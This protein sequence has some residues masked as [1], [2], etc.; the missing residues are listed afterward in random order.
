MGKYKLYKC[1]NS[2]CDELFKLHEITYSFVNDYGWIELQCNKCGSTQKIPVKNPSDYFPGTFSNATIINRYEYEDGEKR[3]FIE[4]PE[5]AIV[6]EEPCYVEWKPLRSNPFWKVGLSGELKFQ[7]NLR[8]LNNLIEKE[9][10]NFLN[11]Y[12][13][14]QYRADLPKKIIVLLHFSDYSITW[15][16]TVDGERDINTNNLYLVNHSRQQGWPDG[17]YDRNTLLV[18]LERC[19]M[20]WKLLAN[21]VVVVTPFI[22]FQYKKKE[23]QENVIALW[24]FLNSRLD[25]NKTLFVTR[26]ETF[27][28]L[29]KNQAEIDVPF[30]TLKEW[31]LI[32]D[33]Q[34]FVEDQKVKTKA[35]FHCKFYAGVFDDHVELFAGSYNIHTG[36]GL[37]QVSMRN[38]SKDSFKRMYMDN[39]VENFCYHPFIDEDVLFV[40]GN[41]ELMIKCNVIKMSEL[42]QIIK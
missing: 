31:H 40:E 19:L 3:E 9:L 42:V 23:Y 8:T 21:Q 11:Y 34:R 38:Y 17:V 32:D 2:D 30:E 22:G 7:N 26:R 4:Q 35:R 36:G 27:T 15:A 29:K 16:K 37:E 10:S 5:F 33:L 13:A 41:S 1:V 39:L 12:L 28:L 20:R 25:M 18:Y 6:T 24:Q 14:G